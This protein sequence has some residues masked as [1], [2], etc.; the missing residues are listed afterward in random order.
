MKEFFRGKVIPIASGG[1]QFIRNMKHQKDFILVTGK[2][3]DIYIPVN[4][5]HRALNDEWNA[6]EEE[7]NLRYKE[8]K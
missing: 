1:I 5:L 3:T 8:V 2:H 4:L 6:D 7:R